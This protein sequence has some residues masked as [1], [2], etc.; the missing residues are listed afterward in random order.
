MKGFTPLEIFIGRTGLPRWRAKS[1]SGE[2]LTGFTLIEVIIGLALLLATISIFGVA[3]STL[4][5]TKTARNQNLAYHLAA[6][7]LE[8]LRN[9]PFAILPPGGSFTDPGLSNLPSS[10]AS[11]T[12]A[13]YQDSSEIK[14]A[15]VTVSWEDQGAARSIELDTLISQGGVSRP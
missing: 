13:D 14:R 15:T 8:E 9:T 5:L 10:T 1:G 2:F 12:I 6:K 3:I 7:K 11:L 4:P